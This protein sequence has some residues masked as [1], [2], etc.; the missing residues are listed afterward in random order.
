[1]EVEIIRGT[2]ASDTRFEKVDVS[3]GSDEKG[4]AV[5][6]SGH[7]RSSEDAVKL[8]QIVESL[9]VKTG[10]VWWVYSN[11]PPGIFKD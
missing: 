8:R 7:V 11:R 4:G 5:V 6:I 3:A 10:I 9:D 1:M 2:L